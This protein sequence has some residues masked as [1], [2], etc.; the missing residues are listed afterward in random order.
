M[1]TNQM[2]VYIT[3]AHAAGAELYACHS[4]E[5]FIFNFSNVEIDFNT[6]EFYR[7]CQPIK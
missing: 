6:L 2:R 1:P 3:W 4:G 7:E 5:K